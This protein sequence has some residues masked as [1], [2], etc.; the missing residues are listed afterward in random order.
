M[1]ELS[2]EYYQGPIEKLLELIEEK[3]L[4]VTM[5]SLSEV[6]AGFFDYLEKLEKEGVGNGIIADFLSV[7]S[8]L[9]LIKSKFILPS[10]VM[11]EE[12]EEDI[13]GLETR[14]KIYQEFKQA[15]LYIK[16]MWSERELMGTREFFKGAAQ[17]FYPPKS[18][19]PSDFASALER[20]IG[21]IEKIMK[22]VVKV[23]NQVISLKKKIEEVFSRLTNDP[24]NFKNLHS[25]N[26]KEVVVLFLAILHLIRQQLIDVE[27]NG[28][29]SDILVAKI[30]P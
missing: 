21:E 4:E 8:K 25:G 13:K 20:V 17:S 19:A 28:R 2:F 3:K 24:V 29:F 22:P 27:Q 18:C 11:T 12:E 10:L 14:I 9:L 5:V 7:A 30:N 1:Y 26:K 23:K 6:T 15:K 16:E